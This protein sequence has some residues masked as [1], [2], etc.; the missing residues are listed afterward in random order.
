MCVL[1]SL[2]MQHCGWHT[3]HVVCVR[4]LGTFLQATGSNTIQTNGG[5]TVTE[6]SGGDTH[7]ANADD[8]AT[9]GTG[10]AGAATNGRGK[11]KNP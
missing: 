7:M 11:R 2:A 1:Q 10:A 6:G 9:T 5:E 3:M 8:T 4:C